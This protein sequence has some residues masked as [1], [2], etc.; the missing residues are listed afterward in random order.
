MAVLG[1]ISFKIHSHQRGLIFIFIY[2]LTLPFMSKIDLNS[3][4]DLQNLGIFDFYSRKFLILKLLFQLGKIQLER[5]ELNK[6]SYF[7]RL[8]TVTDTLNSIIRN[9]KIEFFYK[10]KI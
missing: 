3:I 10:Y 4:C 7:F 6:L 1:L 8:K 9:Q 2:F 5:V